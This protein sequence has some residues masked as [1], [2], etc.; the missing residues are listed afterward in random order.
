[1]LCKIGPNTNEFRQ[2][3]RLVKAKLANLAPIAN[4]SAHAHSRH[5]LFLFKVPEPRAPPVS[6][7]DCSTSWLVHRLP[8]PFLLV[9]FRRV[10][11]GTGETTIQS[12][13]AIKIKCKWRYACATRVLCKF[14]SPVITEWKL[15][16]S[17]GTNG[18]GKMRKKNE[19]KGER[20]RAG[21]TKEKITVRSVLRRVQACECVCDNESRKSGEWGLH[22]RV[23]LTSIV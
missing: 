7:V 10:W 17:S 19:R 8:N 13:T 9:S 14:G 3:K 23:Q 6:V 12:I 21:K 1:M 4:T 16:S 20:A 22:S 5:T 11:E 18:P 15:M 2:W